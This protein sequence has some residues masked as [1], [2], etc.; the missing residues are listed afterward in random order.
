LHEAPRPAIK[1]PAITATPE[2]RTAAVLD[3]KHAAERIGQFKS[4]I[5]TLE[6][7]RARYQQELESYR[8]TVASV[9]RQ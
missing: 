3:T 5:T 6:R 2:E 4:E 8:A 7:D 1:E 9:P